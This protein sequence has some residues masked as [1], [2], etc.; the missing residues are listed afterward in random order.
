MHAPNL[1]PVMVSAL[2]KSKY[3]YFIG[4]STQKQQ[5]RI[6]NI[7]QIKPT[8]KIAYVYNANSM[9]FLAEAMDDQ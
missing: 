4:F 1:T 7:T 6:E 8:I 9:V 2:F 5:I 3:Q